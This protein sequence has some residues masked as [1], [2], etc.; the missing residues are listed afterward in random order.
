[1]VEGGFGGRGWEEGVHITLV[2]VSSPSTKGVIM[3]RG[4]RCPDMTSVYYEFCYGFVSLFVF[5]DQR[6]QAGA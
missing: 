4:L 2:E 6:M 1:M 3:C 5:Y